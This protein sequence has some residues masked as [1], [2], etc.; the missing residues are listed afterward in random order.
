MRNTVQLLDRRCLFPVLAAVSLA[1]M[2]SLAWAEVAGT[3]AATPPA[4]VAVPAPVSPAPTSPAPAATANTFDQARIIVVEWK[5]KKGHEQEFLD[6]WAK[7]SVVSDRT[8]LVAEFMTTPESKDKYPWISWASIDA[9]SPDYSAFYNIGI[10]KQA[11]DYVGQIGKYIDLNRP[12]LP[13]EADKRHRVLLAP[14]EWRIG[15]S[16]LP[17]KDAEGVK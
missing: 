12:S 9:N 10:W 11:G 6:Y 17:T 1:I 13:F 3:P 7:K 4:S 14:A 15:M 2:P 16:S 8:G 5:I